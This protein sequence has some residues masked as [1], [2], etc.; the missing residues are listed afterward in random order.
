MSIHNETGLEQFLVAGSWSSSIIAKVVSD[1]DRC[2]ELRE[3]DNLE[4]IANDIDVYHGP[5]N[6]DKNAT[7]D[8][9]VH[10]IMKC[11]VHGLP[12]ELNMMKCHHL[13]AEGFLANN[14]IS[15]IATCF[16]VDFSKD[17]CL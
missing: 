1:W 9:D 6:E 10:E 5:S 17:N 14:D 2:E 12:W 3:F 8:V 16:E 13:S 11:K 4:L 7:F 15:L